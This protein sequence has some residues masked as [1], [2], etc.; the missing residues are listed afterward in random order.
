MAL[1][2]FLSTLAGAL[3]GLAGVVLGSTLTTRSQRRHWTRRQQ[4]NTCRDVVAQ[5]TE[6]QLALLQLWKSHEQVS[7]T[8]WNQSLAIV[9]LLND[10]EIISAAADIDRI[11]WDC[12]SRI[13]NGSL[14]SDADWKELRDQMEQA[15]LT[16]INV[17]RQRIVRSKKGITQLPISRP[18][19]EYI[20]E[21]VTSIAVEDG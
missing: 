12:S 1:D 4:I 6:T 18:S 15:R 19:A 17:A 3:V 11:F 2:P 13:K 16:F 21:A 10:P 8:K 20:T 9:S 14:R 5:S 7:W